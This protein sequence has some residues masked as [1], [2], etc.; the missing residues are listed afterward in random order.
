[1]THDR[2]FHYIWFNSA[3]FLYFL[4][5]QC[6]LLH[7]CETLVCQH[8]HS[9]PAS[10]FSSTVWYFLLDQLLHLLKT[11]CP[12]SCSF[13]Q[14]GSQASSELPAFSF[15]HWHRTSILLAFCMGITVFSHYLTRVYSHCI[16]GVCPR[17]AGLQALLFPFCNVQ[18]LQCQDIFSN[19][20]TKNAAGP[21]CLFY[22]TKS[23]PNC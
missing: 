4:F 10:R 20:Q 19:Y 21:L 16:A 8:G 18:W 1:M 15:E 17:P 22:S 6:L 7:N 9:V 23:F 2:I 14:P 11:W 12:K 5:L 3:E 13:A